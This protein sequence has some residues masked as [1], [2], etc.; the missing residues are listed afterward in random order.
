[1]KIL[2]IDDSKEIADVF[3]SIFKLKGHEYNHIDNGT[4][5][6][7]ELCNNDY[8]L[9]FLDITMPKINGFDVLK[10]LEKRNQSVQNIMVLTAAFL[11]DD[12]R[13]YLKQNGASG[14]L[15]K[16]LSMEKLFEIL[17]N[18]NKKEWIEI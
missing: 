1:M 17:E 12:E 11:N 7:E 9:T 8:D 14:I 2:H 6:I 13:E 5:G 4:D 18:I 3:S 10:E 15:T 16:P